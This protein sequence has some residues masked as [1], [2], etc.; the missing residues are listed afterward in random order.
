MV[1]LEIE[2]ESE[3]LSKSIVFSGWTIVKGADREAFGTG[4]YTGAICQQ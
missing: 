3:T 4:D 1:G 2:V